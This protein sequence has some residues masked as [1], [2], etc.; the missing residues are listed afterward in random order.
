MLKD[1]EYGEFFPLS[2]S[3]HPYNDTYAMVDF[4]LIKEEVLKN[5]W[6]WYEEPKIPP[7]LL[8]LKLT[9]VKDI[10]K[11]IKDVTD[12]ILNKAIIC[13]VTGKPFRIIKSE[14]DFYRKMNLPL[15]TKHPSQRILERFR[16]MNPSRL[17]KATCKK[18]QKDM[19]TSYSPEKQKELKIYCE[20]CYL[21][22]V[23]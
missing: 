6:Q 9:E 2:M 22:E 17:W 13:E 23:V 15:P 1:E 8:G 11:D 3:L 20:A 21:R 16:E 19:F 18:C 10:P 5:G 12:D 4:P 14:L 7:D